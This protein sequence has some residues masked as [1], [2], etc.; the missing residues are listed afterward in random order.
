MQMEKHDLRLILLLNR[1]I[2]ELERVE[3]N[4]QTMRFVAR[5]LGNIIK[6]MKDL[7]DDLQPRGSIRHNSEAGDEDQS[8]SSNPGMN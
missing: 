4:D 2:E 6:H 5:R 3:D 7:R 8:L 1:S